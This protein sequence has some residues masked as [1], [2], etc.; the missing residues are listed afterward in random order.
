MEIRVFVKGL[1]AGSREVLKSR[2]LEVEKS[3]GGK[4]E[5]RVSGFSDNEH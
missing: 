4:T 5:C 2:S 3:K 1:D